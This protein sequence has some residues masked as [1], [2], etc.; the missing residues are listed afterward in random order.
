MKYHDLDKR[1][2]PATD[3]DI[4]HA[5]K[6]GGELHFGYGAC[7]FIGCDEVEPHFHTICPECGSLDHSN[8]AGCDTCR[9]YKK[10]REMQLKLFGVID[11]FCK[12]MD[13]IAS[14]PDL[15]RRWRL[16][17]FVLVLMVVATWRIGG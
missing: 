10:V 16:L 9:E 13:K 2:G 5:I 6:H 3:R 1:G 4:A 11:D 17:S 7:W 15:M 12:R 14:G 8:S